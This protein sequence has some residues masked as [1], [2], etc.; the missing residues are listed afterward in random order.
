M[1]EYQRK[2]EQLAA[3]AGPLTT[4]QEVEIFISGLQEYIA[5]EV[6]L[7]R[8]RDLISAMSLARLYERRGGAKRF[9]P[10]AY[11]PSSNTSSS[12][13]NQKTFKRLSRTEMDERRAKGLCFNCDEVYNQGHQCK[14]LSWLD[15]VDESVQGDNEDQEIEEDL[16]PE[17]SLHAIMGENFGG[18]TM[19]IQGIIGQHHL[20]ILID[21]G[22]THSFLGSWWVTKLGLTC[23]PKEGLQVV[24]ANGS[25]IRSPGQCQ[26][27]PIT[28]GNQLIHID[29]Y[30]LKL[31]GVDAGFGSELAT[32]NGS[33]PIRFQSQIHG[34]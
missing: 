28:M 32:E 15:G 8:P 2:F 9:I 22:S 26:N 31:N 6:E 20:L 30:I 11:K 17:I 27:V 29:L 34:F 21:L 12:S 14:R 4:E 25:K 7:H 3:R 19:R 5:I 13:S 10:P 18:K 23:E 33:H 16:P 24:V 1:E